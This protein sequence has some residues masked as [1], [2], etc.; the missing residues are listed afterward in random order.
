MGMTC[1]KLIFLTL[2]MLVVTS[3][4]TFAKARIPIGE[5]EVVKKV[6]DLP[7]TD[8]FKLSNGHHF[9]LA[10]R[11][12][13]FNVAYILPL[14]ITQNPKLVGYDEIDESAFTISDQ[15][16][17]TILRLQKQSESQLNQLPFYTQ[18]GGKLVAI[19][20]IAL[21][22]WGSIPSK[23]KNITPQQI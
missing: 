17:Q 14:Y 2:A 5:R 13:E 7:D 15:E 9:D 1:L 6:Y 18:Y 23:R 4:I 22:I 3:N 20:I 11:H 8:A 19:S 21:L 10:T 12:R 16:L